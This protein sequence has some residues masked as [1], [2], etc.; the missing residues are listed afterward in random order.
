MDFFLLSKNILKVY[1]L[2]N[3]FRGEKK[4]N[5][6]RPLIKF[7]QGFNLNLRTGYQSLH[8]AFLSLFSLACKTSILI[9]IF[10]LPFDGKYEGL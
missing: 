3:V 6:C 1:E 5:I 8:S 2:L 4:I 10:L 7:V 9:F